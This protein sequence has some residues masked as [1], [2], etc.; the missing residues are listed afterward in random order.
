ML[1]A[2]KVLFLYCFCSCLKRS[3]RG[4]FCFCVRLVCVLKLPEALG[5]CKVL[6]SYVFLQLPKVLGVSKAMCGF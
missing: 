5:V 4:R 6:L 3:Q 2:C 1:R